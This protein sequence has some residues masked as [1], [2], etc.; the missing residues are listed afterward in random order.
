MTQTLTCPKCGLVDGFYTVEKSGNHVARCR[1]C[2]AFIKNIAY[3]E[4]K[5][6][7]GKY[8]DHLVSAIEDLN[9]LQWALANIKVSQSMRDAIRERI[10]I[11]HE[12]TR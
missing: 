8:K 9:Y 4:P 5:F 12:L 7:F 6:Y 11:L 3:Q 10:N 1:R 2:D